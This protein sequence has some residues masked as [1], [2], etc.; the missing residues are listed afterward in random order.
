MSA[1]SDL[2]PG[3]GPF[4]VQTLS[5]MKDPSGF[6]LKQL[7]KHG[8]PFTAN[9]PI[10]EVVVTGDPTG[11]REIFSAD[12][13]SFEVLGH[14]PLVPAVGENSV[15]VTSG[16]RHRRKRKL[17]MPPFHG[18]RMRAYG[19]LMQELALRAFEDRAPGTKLFA[20]DATT[21]ISLEVIIRA[22]F[23]VT[24]PK[25]A[26]RY[27]EVLNAYIDTYT[28][29]IA[30]FTLLRRNFGGRGPW[31]RFQRNVMALHALLDEELTLRRAQEAST[32]EDILSL[33][34]AARDEDGQPMPDVELKD[35][36][37]TLLLAGHETTAI[38]MAWALHHLHRNPGTLETLLEELDALGEQ[39]TPEALAAAPYLGAVCDEALRLKPVLAGVARRTR[40][41]FTL[42]GRE[43]PVGTP[44]LAAV[45]VAHADPE[46][47]PEPD[48]FRPE[49]FLERRYSPFEYLP[50]GGGARRCIGAAFALYEM[51]VVLGTLLTTHRFSAAEGPPEHPVRR[52][53]TLGPSRKCELIYEGRR[54]NGKG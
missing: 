5:W 29:S 32:D 16:V 51:R 4:L 22:V 53:V 52:N 23:G 38:S 41:P 33:L 46:I 40:V 7:A 21:D 44:L 43:L 27:R 28:P 11:I 50:F 48:A 30:A 47:F 36:L 10:G 34:L 2:I 26:A 35:E 25:R 9:L 17:L 18:E 15:L 24:D 39:P 37:R 54:S 3:S 12:P 13:D 42:Q 20:Q 6:Y 14:L 1:L 31:A 45:S 19:K 8:Q 49:R